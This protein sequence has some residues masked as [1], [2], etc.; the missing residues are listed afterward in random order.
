MANGQCRP[1][2]SIEWLREELRRLE[3][4][5]S[6][7]VVTNFHHEL[8]FKIEVDAYGGYRTAK[9][10]FYIEIEFDA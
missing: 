10:K 5:L 7:G 8:N 2:G 1:D 9:R 6:G 3:A 4:T